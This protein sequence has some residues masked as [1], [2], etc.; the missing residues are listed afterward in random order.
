MNFLTPESEVLSIVRHI[1]PFDDLEKI[2]IQNTINWIE[3]GVTIYRLQKPAIPPKHLVVSCMVYDPNAKKIFLV[4]HKKEKMWLAPGGHVE[5]SESPKKA[6][7]RECIEELGK[8]LKFLFDD[9]VL[10]TT[11]I[12]GAHL[13]VN[14]WYALKGDINETYNI[15]YNEFNDARWFSFDEIPHKKAEPNIKRFINKVLPPSNLIL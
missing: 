11:G 9:P 7:E 10:L 6:A 14:L 15:D 4:D 5:V 13:D 3:S 2:D 12:S 1:N 8:P